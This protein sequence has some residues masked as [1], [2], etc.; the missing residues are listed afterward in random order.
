MYIGYTF[1]SSVYIVHV[2]T[3]NTVVGILHSKYCT[4]NRPGQTLINE[5]YCDIFLAINT[6][7]PPCIEL[8]CPDKPMEV[9]G[10]FCQCPCSLCSLSTVSV[11]NFKYIAIVLSFYFMLHV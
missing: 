1:T 5:V 10:L 2:C 11:L 9:D 6:A 8:Y 3:D 4:V 7:V